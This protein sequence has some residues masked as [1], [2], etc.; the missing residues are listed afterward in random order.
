MAS[1]TWKLMGT[2]SAIVT[3]IAARKV[4]TAA[5]TKGTGQAPPQNPESPDT[6]WQEALVWALVSGALIGVARMLAA[7]KAA[8]I[9]RSATG[10]LPRGLQDVG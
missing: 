7:R 2:G 9:Y 1:F 6:T 3:G 5:W 10:H 4:I 8:D